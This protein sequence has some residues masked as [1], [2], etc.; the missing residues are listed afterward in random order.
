MRDA[1]QKMLISISEAMNNQAGFPV[2]LNSSTVMDIQG[3]RALRGFITGLQSELQ[4]P[5]WQADKTGALNAL[6]AKCDNYASVVTALVD[7]QGASGQWELSFVPPESTDESDKDIV[8]ICR[9]AQ[10]TI[11]DLPGDWTDL[12]VQPHSAQLAG[13]AAANTGLRLSIRC[14]RDD[15]TSEVFKRNL[16]NWGLVR[17]IKDP[18]LKAERLDEGSRWRFTVKLGVDRQG[19]HNGSEVF[20]AKLLG[21]S[22]PKLEEWPTQ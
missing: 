11:G 2:V 10:V 17:L 1:R 5:V 6:Q 14:L 16:A 20:E 21:G 4:D 7:G 22:L 15:P 3:L 8:R 9:D 12:A 19:W 18:E 13:K